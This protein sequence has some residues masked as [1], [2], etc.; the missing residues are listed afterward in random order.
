M[1]V[2]TARFVPVAK[3]ANASKFTAVTV[4]RLNHT[5]GHL[6]AL[7]ALAALNRQGVEIEYKIAGAGPE[8]ENIERHI[9]DLNL[10]RQVTLL[11]NLGEQA[12]GQLLTQA[13]VFLLTSFGL[14]EAAPVSVMEAMASGTPVISSRIGGTAEMIDD[15]VDGLL[16]SQK[17]VDEIAAALR[18]LVLS[19]ELRE[20]L[21]AAARARAT[22]EFDFRQ[23]AA[24]LFARFKK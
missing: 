1:G 19:P 6:Y 21:A 24:L 9:K 12:V 22:R 18:R 15:G 3:S 23:N 2:D 4:A 20:Q 17:N 13:D 8:R 14:G 16:V 11:G 5:K 10:S 7:E